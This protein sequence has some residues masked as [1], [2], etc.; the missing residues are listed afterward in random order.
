MSTKLRNPSIGK[1]VTVSALTAL[2]IVLQFVSMSLRFTAF[3]ITLTLIP[4]VIGGALC[5]IGAGAWLGLVFGI[6]V[7]ASG[8][9]AAFMGI[10]VA[11]TIITV[12]VKGVLAGAASAA[13]YRLFRGLNRYLAT[14]IAAIVAPVVNSGIFMLGCYLFFYDSI[15][16]DAN[17]Q[18]I[19]TF[20]FII[21]FYV[22]VNFIIELATNV[23][24]SPVAVRV[25]DLVAKR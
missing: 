13:S 11:G 15:A 10:S 18:G 22:G 1:M 12:L 6:I 20:A 8:D 24:L 7:L 25:I 3:S 9:A 23:I 16:A 14:V 21:M 5:G 2:V 4:I 19:G 17:G